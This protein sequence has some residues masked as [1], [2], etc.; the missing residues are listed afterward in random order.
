VQGY[1]EEGNKLP[2]NVRYSS[3]QELSNS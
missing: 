3:K 1:L 2:M